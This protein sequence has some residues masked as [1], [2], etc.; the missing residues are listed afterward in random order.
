[1]L[2]LALVQLS[3]KHTEIFG[4][5]IELIV[6]KLKWDLTIYY[7]LDDDR[8]TFVPYYQK[9]F[10]TKIN[11]LPTEEL[12]YNKNTHDFFI[13]TSSIDKL[14]NVFMVGMCS[15]CVGCCEFPKVSTCFVSVVY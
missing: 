12:K 4:V 15:S 11:V 8:Y 6:V 1:M 5:F 2:N 9:L 13:F 3:K 10:K 14:E 7:N